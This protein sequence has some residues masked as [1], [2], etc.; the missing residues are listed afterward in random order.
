[1]KYAFVTLS[2]LA[3]WISV[4]L[5]V[6][7]LNYEGTLLPILALFMTVA[8]FLIGFGSKKW[9]MNLYLVYLYLY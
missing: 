6:V 3:I 8:L 2:I 4:I 9:E 5:I 1:M 7:F